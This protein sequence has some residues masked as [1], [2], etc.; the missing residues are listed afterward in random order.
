MRTRQGC[1]Q[2][3]CRVGGDRTPTGGVRSHILVVGACTR[4]TPWRRPVT[5]LHVEELEFRADDGPDGWVPLRLISMLPGNP[6]ESRRRP[7]VIFLHATGMQH[8]ADILWERPLK[9]S[10]LQSRVKHAFSIC[11]HAGILLQH[12]V[13][14][15]PVHSP[16][17]V[18]DR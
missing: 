8:A 17:G 3:R 6:G 5:G 1:C 7:V 13:T 14:Q 16:P 11:L 10:L 15:T 18:S 9:C 4:L 12:A 2:T